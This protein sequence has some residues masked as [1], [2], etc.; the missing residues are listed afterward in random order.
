MANE[1]SIT[2]K[3][4]NP[5]AAVGAASAEREAG[6][7]DA[8]AASLTQKAHDNRGAPAAKRA[9]PGKGQK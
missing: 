5:M 8:R 9:R 6:K 3:L 2:R 4:G 1:K 7:K